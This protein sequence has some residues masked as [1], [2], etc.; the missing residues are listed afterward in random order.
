MTYE[1]HIIRAHLLHYTTLLLDFKK[2]V[3]FVR[4]T[5]NPVMEHDSITQKQREL[6]KELLV[7]ECGNLLREIERLEMNRQLQNDRVQNVKHLVITRIQAS[8][9]GL[10]NN[11]WIQVYATVNIE[12]SK[13]MKRLSYITMIF[14]PGSFIAVSYSL[15]VVAEMDVEHLNRVFSVWTL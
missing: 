5:N 15:P 2:S 8:V 12:D 6:D 14:L 11:V 7:Q 3:I 1:L 10:S 13:A 9:R 4:D